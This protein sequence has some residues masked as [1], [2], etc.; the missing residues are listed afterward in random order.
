[1]DFDAPFPIVQRLWLEA[2]I[3]IRIAPPMA[4]VRKP[5]RGWALAGVVATS[6]AE[7]G[8]VAYLVA[9]GDGAPAWVHERDVVTCEV[10]EL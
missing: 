3:A 6:G 10:R 1:M 9:S 7:A 5:V 2:E 4:R 8:N